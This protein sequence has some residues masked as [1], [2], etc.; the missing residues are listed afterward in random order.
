M[1]LAVISHTE[2]YRRDDGVIVGW[3][4]TISELNHL[5]PHFEE[6]FHLAFLWEE[7]PPQSALPYIAPN[8]TFIPLPRQGGTSF[9]SKLSLLTKMPATLQKVYK[10]LKGVDAF[11]VR[12]PT[13]M[14]V[15]LIPLLTLFSKK[16]GWFKY[17][18]NWNQDHPPLG[19]ALQ[20]WFLRHQS[21]KVTINGRW[22]QQPRQ[23]VSFEN[24]CLT[25][26]ERIQGLQEIENKN[27]DGPFSFCFVG[28]LEDEK[29]VQRILEVIEQLGSHPKMKEFHLIGDGPKRIEYEQQA[30]KLGVPVHFHGFL[31]R[32]AV[33][34]LYR[35]CHFL[36]LPSTAS[37]GFP[38]VIAEG[39]NF[40][41]LPLVSSVSSISQ[42]VNEKNGWILN[43]VTG[44][45]LLKTM[46]EILNQKGDILREKAGKA[47]KDVKGFTFEQ[48][49]HR[50]LSEILNN[51]DH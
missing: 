35:K 15:Y 5:A 18:G 13:G 23:C 16:K 44:E 51:K 45:Q 4:P 27:Y 41:C 3:G 2:H 12:T 42:Y 36:V 26:I 43:P 1:K 50:I 28:R 30:L 33:F 25:D 8:I 11:Q 49:N 31:N 46:H 22:P 17:A 48:Y 14:G 34:E 19:Y 37:E 40:G 20:R 7:V 9:F 10:V 21:R 29:G 38:K 6:I 47:H 39:M 32:N 24:P